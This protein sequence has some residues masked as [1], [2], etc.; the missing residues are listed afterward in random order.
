VDSGRLS[1]PFWYTESPLTTPDERRP[2]AGRP[3]RGTTQTPAPGILVPDC[4]ITIPAHPNEQRLRQWV[5]TGI[6]VLAGSAIPTQ[7]ICVD[8]DVAVVRSFEE[9]DPTATL[10]STL[11]ARNDEIWIIRPDGHIAAILT[12]PTQVGPAISRVLGQAPASHRANDSRSS[13]HADD[14]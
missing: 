14:S 10:T 4:A 8:E 7:Q 9:L 13:K 12:D 2:F 6:T 3:P 1:E 11:S 5:R